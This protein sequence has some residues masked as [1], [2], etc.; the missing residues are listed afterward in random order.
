MTDME[1]RDMAN[2]IRTLVPL[3]IHP[4][5]VADLR[6]LADHYERL[7]RYLEVLP[8]TLPDTPREYRRQ[9]G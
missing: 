2:E 5:A 4:K 7:A 8:G 1:Y 3:L 6:S 9:A